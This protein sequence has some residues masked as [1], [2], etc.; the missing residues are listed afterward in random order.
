MKRIGVLGGSFDPVHLAHLAVAT[1]AQEQLSLDQVLFVPA[2]LAWQKQ[3]PLSSA[4]HRVAMLQAALQDM[5]MWA[6]IDACE[7]KRPGPSYMIDTLHDLRHRHPHCHFYLIL[8][9][10]QLLNFPT[11]ARWDEI[12]ALT[13]LAVA[14]RPEQTTD[15]PLDV[16]AA[17]LANERSMHHINLPL[18]AISSTAIRVA[19]ASGSDLTGLVPSAVAEYIA[20]F[21]LYKEA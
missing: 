10:D 14:Q 18:S 1:A 13:D 5:P 9:Q 8:G 2:G 17:L 6:A 19:A 20:R 3:R 21:N 4:L 11:W 15:T 12:I 16:R 7:L